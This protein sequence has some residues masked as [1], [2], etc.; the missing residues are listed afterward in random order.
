MGSD[1]GIVPSMFEPGGLV[2][3]EY[4]VADTPVICGETGGLKDTVFDIR[5]PNSSELK[6]NGFLFTPGDTEAL[7]QSILDAEE[8]Y[9]KHSSVVHARA[10]SNKKIGQTKYEILVENCLDTVID[11]KD[12][13]I[14]Y[15]QEFHRLKG[16]VYIPNYNSQI[17]Y[18]LKSI[19][20]ESESNQPTIIL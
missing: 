7:T 14:K 11:V 12:A 3:L 18:I 19:L 20:Q 2:Q 16:S 4:L 6:P 5:A 9:R 10:T 8:L 1:Y 13:A 17:D 15:L